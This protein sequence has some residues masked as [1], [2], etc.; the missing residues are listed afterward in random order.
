MDSLTEPKQIEV[1]PNQEIE[2][3]LRVGE[4]AR[5]LDIL[6][7]TPLPRKITNP[8]Y[9]SISRQIEASVTPPPSD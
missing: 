6:D 2:I 3:K 4:A 5:I 7:E 1:D 8:L 9:V